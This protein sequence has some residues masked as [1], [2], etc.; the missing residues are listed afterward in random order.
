MLEFGLSGGQFASAL[1]FR[2]F[3]LSNY[4]LQWPLYLDFLYSQQ[5]TC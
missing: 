1:D 2:S 4:S 3:L 5:F